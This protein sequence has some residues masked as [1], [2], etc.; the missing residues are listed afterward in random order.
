M[1]RKILVT[2]GAGLIGSHLCQ[3]LLNDGHEVLCL[4]NLSSGQESNL[5]LFKS[6]PKFS[7]IKHDVTIPFDLNVDH[8]YNLASPASPLQYQLEPIQTMKTN[9]LGAINVLDLAVKYKARVFQASTSEVYGD[10]EE[11]PQKESYWGKV[12]PYGVRSCYDEGKRSAESLFFDYRRQHG[13][14]IRVGRIFNT[15]GPRMRENDGRIISN[16]ILQAL[17]NKEITIFGSGEQ[18]RSFCYVDDMVLGMI[19][20]MNTESQ[21]TPVNLGNPVES[22]V[23]NIA[24]L[25]LELTIS[26]SELIHRPLPEDD[27]KKR[28]PDITLAIKSFG[29]EPKIHLKE[30]LSKTINYFRDQLK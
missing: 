26:D 9:V 1:K 14:E 16:F 6:H 24:R 23:L 18:T 17:H 27:P 12:N 13:V 20:L 21:S 4:D 11:H 2:G 5:E 30:G 28:C 25:I 10:P 19:S 22:S 7:F 29:W 8:I 15:Y 3:R